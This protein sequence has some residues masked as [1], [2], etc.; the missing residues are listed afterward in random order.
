MVSSFFERAGIQYELIRK[1]I[2]NMHLR[3]YPPDGRV[4][5]TAPLRLSFRAIDDFIS[6]KQ[7]WIF[8]HRARLQQIPGDTAPAFLTGET[9]WYLGEAYTLQLLQASG[10]PGCFIQ[11]KNLYLSIQP[12]FSSTKKE[13]LLKKWYHQELTKTL[14]E[15]IPLWESL[16]GVNVKGFRIRSMKSRWGSCNPVTQQ[17]CLN[18]SLI[19]KPLACLEYVVVHELV[20]LLEASHNAR[21]YKFMQL[22]LPD[23]KTRHQQLHENAKGSCL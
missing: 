1:P 16:I 18:L 22:F 4:R 23:W 14:E 13:N 2:K 21:F 3:I 20:H 5:V 17:I 7:E 6:L 12:G 10:K 9:H 15:I 11:E 19:K 8:A